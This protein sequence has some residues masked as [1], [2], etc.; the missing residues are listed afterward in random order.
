M[1]KKLKLLF[2]DLRTGGACC[3][4]GETIQVEQLQD[5]VLPFSDGSTQHFVAH[6]RCLRERLHPD[7]PYLTPEELQD[8]V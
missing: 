2:S 6:G 8:E 3:V 7:A 4:C 1:L 5:I